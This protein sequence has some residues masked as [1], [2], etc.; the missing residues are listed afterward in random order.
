MEDYAASLLKQLTARLYVRDE[1]QQQQQ[2][3][4]QH[5]HQQESRPRTVSSSS[6]FFLNT[7]PVAISAMAHP[8]TQFAQTEFTGPSVLRA[9]R[10]TVGRATAKAQLQ[11]MKDS[12]QYDAFRV[13]ERKKKKKEKEKQKE[14]EKKGEEGTRWPCTPQVYWDSDV[15]KWIEGACYLLAEEYDAE[16]DA[17]VRELADTIRGA[18][19]EDGY[20]NTWFTVEEPE[21]RWTNIRDK[22]ELYCAGHLIE[23]A[24]AHSNYYKNNLLLEP[25]EKYVQLIS[26]VIGPGPD[27]KHAYPGHP[28]TELAL[29]RLYTATGNEDAYKLAKYFVEE[30]GNPTGQDGLPYYEWERRQRGESPYQRPDSYLMHDSSWYN[31]AHAPILEQKTVE[32][33]AVRAMYPSA[34]ISILVLTGVADLLCLDELGVRP[35]EHKS[36]YFEA[37][38]RLW[39]NMVDRKMYLTGGIGSMWQ[40]EGFGIDYFLPQGSDEGGC[41]NETCASIAVIML[42]ERLL[43]LDLNA[44]YADIMELCLYNAVMTGLSLDGTAFTYVNQLASSESDK[45]RREDWFDTSCCPP[46]VMRLFGCLGGYLWDYGGTGKGGDAYINVHLYTSAKVTFQV[47]DQQKQQQQIMLEQKSNWPWEGNTLFELQAP[48]SIGVTIRL[49]IPSWA[50]GNFTLTPSHKA[51]QVEKGYLVLP[52]AYTS[53]NRAFSIQIDGFEPRF[54]APHP[55]ANQS[56]LTLARGPLIYCVEDVDNAWEQDHF[57]NVGIRSDSAVAEREEEMTIKKVVDHHHHHHQIG[58]RYVGLRSVGWIRKVIGDRTESG[59]GI[60]P[61]TSLGQTVVAEEK[62]LNFIPY[63]LRA[64]RGGRGHMRVGLLR[65]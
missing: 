24:L 47:E 59:S 5:Q 8:Q 61:G 3:Q 13:D 57:R 17:A 18:Q 12:G 28:E 15:A 41:Y 33:H 36:E 30:R 22:H 14:T 26:T 60:E 21:A 44:K 37:L 50:R 55:Y 62:E 25:L 64:N 29:L 65:G 52:A 48:A 2:E 35:Y 19:R 20:L 54:I 10:T 38:T 7:R 51:A 31:Q 32:G 49:R 39:N 45:S 53:A 34:N 16:I 63:Y 46:N 1:Q 11:R 6:P 4:E 58:E 40:W 23:A 43:H 9:R 42:A 56:T 27:Q